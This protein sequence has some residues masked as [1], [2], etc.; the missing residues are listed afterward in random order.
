VATANT[1]TASLSAAD[2]T[3]AAGSL[4]SN[5]TLPTTASGAG[6]ITTVTLTASIIGDPTRPYNG[7]T[8]VTLTSGNFSL[9]GLVGPESFT[10]TQTSGTY[11][12]KDVATAD[13]VTANLTTGDFTPGAGTL[14]SNY[15]LP[16]S[17][18]GPGHITPR[19]VTLTGTRT[20]DGMPDAAFGIL[21]V[22]NAV[23][24]DIVTVASGTATLA[25]KNVGTQAITSLGT[26]A[27]GGGA[28]GNYT[29]TGATGSV[30]ISTLA[31][32]INAV[33]DS[34]TYNGSA[35]STATAQFVTLVGTDTG[36]AVQVF[37]SKN[38]GPRTLS[39]SSYTINDGNN[40]NNYG[41]ITTNTAAGSISTL[42]LT[43]NAVADSRTYNGYTDS[44]KTP[45]FMTLVGTD[46]GTA[47]Q[48]FDSKNAGNRTLSV[49]SY[50]INDGNNGN[51]YGPITKNTAAGSISTLALTINA[52]ADTK[53]FD[54]TTDSS[55]TP[56]FVMLVDVDSGSAVQ[57]F[58]SKNAGNRTL[59]VSSYTISDGNGGAN[60]GPVTKNT[61]AGTINSAQT[62]TGVISSKNPSALNEPVTFTATVTNTQTSPIPTGTVTFTYT[63]AALNL[64]GTLG[65]AS[66][67]ASGKAMLSS[68][69]LPV[70]SNV[71]KATY[72]N[73]DGNFVGGTYGTVTQ[74]ANYIFVGFLQP[75]DNLP[76]LNSAKG[77]QTIPIKWQLKDYAGN[78]ISDLGTLAP[79]GLTSGSIQCGAQ[80]VDV[81]EELSAPGSTVFRFDG[82]QFIYN[83]QTSKS[84][85][86]GCRTL[87]VRLSD[88]IKFFHKFQTI[89]S[90]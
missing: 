58:D 72:N 81:I 36:T 46:T 6:H 34:R 64:S 5:Y 53:T 31:L 79:N 68:A 74:N 62:A 56:T 59:S 40:G 29:L 1:I 42:A 19:A 75:I 77:G 84:W 63:N 30:T 2:F 90:F 39:V 71:V 37:D 4:A 12:S 9:S 21:T 28:A 43:I 11:N 78:L 24:T 3:P 49:S 67:D 85:T 89:Y 69:A 35:T 66:V 88:G 41:P 38:A 26:L 65:T 50:M 20:Y 87:Q 70:N 33:A 17:V 16:T 48:V 54:G 32:T 25:S 82:T 61:A 55:K 10:V 45:T 18:S 86:G 57:V 8:D 27:L 7:D 15:T 14:A 51:N 44:S 23:G 83:W 13:T 52:V 22:S 76:T 80:P 47:V 60:Y 73:V